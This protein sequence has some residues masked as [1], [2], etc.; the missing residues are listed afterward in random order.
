MSKDSK[1]KQITLENLDQAEKK[2]SINKFKRLGVIALVLCFVS[3]GA[4]AA[5][6]I[7]SG[8]VIASRFVI[9]KMNCPACIVTVKEITEKIPGVVKTE[10]SLSAGDATIQYREKQT[11]PEQ[12]QAAIVKAGYPS[13]IDG[14]AKKDGK[15]SN[16]AIAL[17]NGKPVF[18]NDL[19]IPIL[20]T[21]DFD[22]KQD[23]SSAVFSVLG[24][25]ILLQSADSKMVVIQPSEVQEEI[26]SMLKKNEI[27]REAFMAQMISKFGS[28]EKFLQAV[29]QKLGI[30]RLI[31]DHVAPGIK[32]TDERNRKTLEWI[33]GLFKDSDVQILDETIRT[34]MGSPGSE[35]WKVFWPKMIGRSSDLKSILVQTN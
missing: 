28:E 21:K 3:V 22:S 16:Q 19:E 34:Q 14:I 10:V 5:F 29:A 18:R 33:G 31:E 27:S 13:K 11:N 4:Y 17:V 30:Q 25:E 7:I 23:L 1:L 32:E 24:K 26:D 12:I 2:I 8:D 9:N 35:G 20:G 15:S 6:R